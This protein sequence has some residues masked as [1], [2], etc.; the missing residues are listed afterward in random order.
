MALEACYTFFHK[1]PNSSVDKMSIK[2]DKSPLVGFV[3][4]RFTLEEEI[5]VLY[6]YE[7]SSSLMSKGKDYGNYLCNKLSLLLTRC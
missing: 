6:V 2:L 7:Y 3:N 4:Y 5:H 1:A